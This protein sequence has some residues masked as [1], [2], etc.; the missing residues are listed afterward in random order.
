MN[1]DIKTER[2]A[3]NPIIASLGWWALWQLT[4]IGFP[5]GGGIAYFLLKSVDG[6]LKGLLAGAIAGLFI[7]TVQ[8]PVLRRRSRVQV[9]WIVATSL[10]LA[11]GLAASIAVVGTGTEAL[12]VLLR[13]AIAGIV[14]GF[15]QWLVLREAS[16]K[17]LWWVF[18]MTCSW[19]LG[20]T[21]SRAVGVDLSYGWAVFGALGALA[22]TVVTGAVLI[23]LLPLSARRSVPVRP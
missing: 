22:F 15:A 12:P 9:W 21:V 20:W 16:P 19:A 2:T 17:A 8:W 5:I 10:G 7:G 11:L 3:M 14:V 6:P 18:V 1:T 23:V 13:G 4:F